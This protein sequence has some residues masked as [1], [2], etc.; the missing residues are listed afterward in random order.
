MVKQQQR[1]MVG[2]CV[3]KIPWLLVQK[4]V[5]LRN[6]L[7]L[8]IIRHIHVLRRADPCLR[9][10]GLDR[11][12]LYKRVVCIRFCRPQGFNYL[13]CVAQVFAGH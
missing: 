10:G 12:F 2:R 13:G 5:I 1:I 3:L 7:Q 11:R 4:V 8:L 6:N 9:L